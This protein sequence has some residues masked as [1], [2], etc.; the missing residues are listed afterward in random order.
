MRGGTA[1]ERA[2]AG[3]LPDYMKRGFPIRMGEKEGQPNYLYGFGLP[4]EDLGQLNPTQL[5]SR[6][7]P[8]LKYPI[9][10]MT[11]KNLYFDRPL[12]EVTNAPQIL[13]KAP[14]PIKKWFGYSET[15]KKSGGVT[16]KL[17]PY[18]WHF[19][20]NLLGRGIFT[21]DKL[22][23][24]EVLPI[25][26]ALYFTT[27]IKGKAVDI[28][29][30]EYWRTMERQQQLEKYLEGKGLMKKFTKYYQPKD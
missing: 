25:I 14:A 27:G 3:A 10:K 6:L 1:E 22:S 9:E 15:K 2:E 12:D 28:E 26:K 19:I 11:N 7:S 18:K 13:G 16:R 29:S 21:V 8:L 4:M 17:D 24:P 5:A 23:D 20:T 30:E